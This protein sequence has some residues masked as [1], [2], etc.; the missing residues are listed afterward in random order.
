MRD[1]GKLL[2]VITHDDKY[3]DIADVVYKM[4][5][6]TISALALQD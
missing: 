6:G 4:E 1:E 5:L 3:F 2:I